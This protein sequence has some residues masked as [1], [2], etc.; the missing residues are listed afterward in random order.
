MLVG[1]PAS[2]KTAVVEVMACYPNATIANDLTIKQASRL[3]EDMCGGKIITMGFLDFAKLYQRHASTASNIEGFIRALTAEGFR[4][5]NW[6]D[7]RTQCIPAR[8]LVVGCMTQSFYMGKYTNW[9]E[10]GFSRRFLWSVYRL[11][12]PDLIIEAIIKET[13]IEFFNGNGRGFNPKIPTTNYIP[14]LCT[15]DEAR[16]L[17]HYLRYQDA[18]EIGLSMLKKLFSALKWKFGKTHS[19]EP[20]RIIADFAESLT[21]DGAVL[22]I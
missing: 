3:R 16:Q 17:N 20:M 12:N 13:K 11:A 15:Q 18:R 8:A 1:P 9:K 19:K 5:V 22:H 6:E 21:K 10:D 4:Q 14:Q 7:S 2:L